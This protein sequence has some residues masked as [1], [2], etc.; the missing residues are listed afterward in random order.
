MLGRDPRVREVVT[1]EDGVEALRLIRDERFDG[2][3]LDVRM[4]GLDGLEIARILQ[5]FADPPAV[6]FVSAFEEHAVDAYRL[7]AVDYLL[8]PARRDRVEM[9]VGRVARHAAAQP[10]QVEPP[11]LVPLETGRGLSFIAPGSIHFAE[12]SGDHVRIHTDRGSFLAHLSLAALEERLKAYGFVRIHRHFLLSVRH[13]SGF[14]DAPG[15]GVVRVGDR[16][17]PVSR[18]QARELRGILARFAR[19]VRAAGNC[20]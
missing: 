14:S 2:V 11:P 3:F 10:R 12:A 4:P 1:A 6:V 15:G 17:L 7:H 18:R 20:S 16:Q 13:L 9:A 8:K 5:Q 19:G